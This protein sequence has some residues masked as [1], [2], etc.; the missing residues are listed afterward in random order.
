M[1]ATH[2]YNSVAISEYR[3][4]RWRRGEWDCTVSADFEL[5]STRTDFHLRESLHAKKG[6][7]EFFSC[8]QMTVIKRHLV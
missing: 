5:T 4:T 8:E 6:D 2:V 7:Q 3:I 1:A